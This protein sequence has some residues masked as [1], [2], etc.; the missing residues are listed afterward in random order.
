VQ[1][2]TAAGRAQVSQ[3]NSSSSEARA[4][5]H[6]LWGPAAVWTSGP[7]NSWRSNLFKTRSGTLGISFRCWWWRDAQTMWVAIYGAPTPVQS[8]HNMQCDGHWKS[9]TWTHANTHS[10]YYVRAYVRGG[11]TLIQVAASYYR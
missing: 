7:Y 2:R 6:H 4:S 3:S 5:W 8:R 10:N 9:L 11:R 1:Q